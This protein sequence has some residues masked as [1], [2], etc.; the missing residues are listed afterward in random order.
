VGR[1]YQQGYVTGQVVEENKQDKQL[2]QTK[3]ADKNISQG[4]LLG[5]IVTCV[6]GLGAGIIYFLVKTNL[7]QSATI[8]NVPR[9]QNSPIPSPLPSAAP[10]PVVKIVPV[11][12][13]QPRE[14][15]V[16]V[17]TQP[18]PSKPQ[19][20]TETVK[21]TKPS[22]K[23][24]TKEISPAPS[25]VT[26]NVTNTTNTKPADAPKAAVTDDNMS[27]PKP[28][29]SDRDLKN[30]I[31]RTFQEQFSDNKLMVEVNQTNVVVSG[32]VATPEQLKRIKPLLLSIQGIGNIKI[33]AIAD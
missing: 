2:N 17:T 1:E 13:I 32:S 10:P 6:A 28:T 4:L 19:A 12:Q 8:I 29:R 31:T 30:E 21:V 9:Q 15:K 3:Q 7:P 20:K 24:S 22:V 25:N 33:V 27:N 5:V 18:E 26:N 16:N 11:P 14:V 23:A